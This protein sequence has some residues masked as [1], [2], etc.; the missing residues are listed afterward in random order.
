MLALS[1][2]SGG[3]IF[4]SFVHLHNHS[5]YSLLDGASR[6]KDLIRTAKKNNMPAIALTDH[7]VLYGAVEFYKEAIKEGIKPILGCEVYVA[8]RSRFDK[9]GRDRDEENAYHLILLAENQEGWANLI[10]LVSKGHLEG[11]Y[12]KPRVDKELL[13]EYSGGLIALSACLAGEIPCLYMRGDYEGAE[14]ALDEYLDIFGKDHFFLEVQDHGL[15]IHKEVNQFIFELAH[16]KEVSVVATN[17]THY[18]SHTDAK[19]QDALMCIQMQKDLHD[20]NRM[21]FPS[22]E[23]YLKKA[24]EMRGLFPGHSEVITN[25]LQIAERCNV[26]IE[27]GNHLLPKFPVPENKSASGYLKE[28]CES[29]LSIRYTTITDFHKNRLEHELKVINEMGFSSYFLIVWDFVRFA[30]TKDIP[31]G[32]GR[33]SA[34]GS[35]VAYLLGITNVDP[36]EYELLFERFLNPERITMPDID[37]DFC[38]ERRG[39][40][41]EYVIHKYGKG[42]VAQ[43]ITFGTLAARAAVRDVGRV[44]GMSYGDVDRIAKLI[45]RELGITLDKSLLQSKELKDLYDQNNEVQQLM[46]L[47]ISIEGMPRNAST[48]AAGVVITPHELTHYVPLQNSSEG[49]VTTQWDK[50]RVEELGLLKMDLLGLTTLTIIQ[51][52]LRQIEFRTGEKIDIDQIPKSDGLVAQMFQ[53]GKTAGI[54]QMESAGMTE[55]VRQIAPKS[56]EELIPL[57]ALFRPGPLGSGMVDDFIERKHG[58][59]EIS[60]AHPDLEEILSDTFGVI[61]YQE[62]VMKI[63][64]TM[65]GF[66][67]GEADLLRRAMSKKKAEVIASE[68]VH[69]VE[70]ALKKGYQKELA[71]SIFDLISHFADYGF[72]K[73]HSAPYALL[74]YQTAWL[75]A[76]HPAEFMASILSNSLRATDK[77]SYYMDVCRQMGLKILPPDIHIS[78]DSFQVDQSGNIRFGL[79]A[80]KNIGETAIQNI[81]KERANGNFSSFS[82]FCNRVDTRVVNKRVI[83]NL[84]KSGALD[85][86]DLK[87]TQLLAILDSAIDQST[88]KQKDS[89]AGFMDL[90]TLEDQQMEYTEIIVPDIS[91]APKEELMAWEKELTGFYVSHHPLDT[92]KEQLELLTGITYLSGEDKSWAGVGGIILDSKRITTQKGEQMCFLTLE[93]YTSAIEVVIFPKIFERYGKYIFPESKIVIFGK[94]QIE[95]EKAPKIIAHSLYPLGE[96]QVGLCLELSGK[97]EGELNVNRIQTVLRK[98]SGKMPVFLKIKSQNKTIKAFEELWINPTDKFFS[99]II[100]IIPENQIIFFNY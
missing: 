11:F 66:S 46:D 82:D 22:D 78:R 95:D 19:A 49:W 98:Y 80:V 26:E 75:K 81:V 6:I 70:G 93:D 48:H 20:T 14:K 38:Y 45:P 85:C 92:F 84:A 13:R 79:A 24:D 23:F 53:Q 91:E 61:L 3:E 1:F 16:K 42:R 35:I 100:K 88:R 87:R 76:H 15:S 56:F 32:P 54:F 27:F 74:A 18:I 99:E 29:A 73:S 69:F 10:Q 33:G 51:N 97:N 62:Q 7:G 60:Y 58:R 12:Y 21:K 37:I 44:L 9:N 47:A 59:K 25:T 40:I 63:A 8:P 89:A 5:E 30:K 17:D 68:R 43:I 67:L 34:A 71:E 55:L 90:F 77:M 83:E 39:E 2:Y 50:D 31:V 65:A 28:L 36:I 96:V 41:I 57:V 4:M 86:F 64:S 94:L 72:N 52:T